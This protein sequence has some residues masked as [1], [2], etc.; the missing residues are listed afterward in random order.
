MNHVPGMYLYA[1]LINLLACL[2]EHLLPTATAILQYFEFPTQPCTTFSSFHNRRL[3]LSL[4]CLHCRQVRFHILSLSPVLSSPRQVV[5][6]HDQPI[7]Q[8]HSL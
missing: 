1:S 3:P 8:R 2:I 4:K 6:S 7:R 5:E